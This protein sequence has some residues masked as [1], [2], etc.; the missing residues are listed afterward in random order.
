MNAKDKY[1]LARL[2]TNILQA[3][4]LFQA[5]AEGSVKPQEM[6]AYAQRGAMMLSG[7]HQTL[8]NLENRMTPSP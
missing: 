7:A 3:R 5:M 4:N 2:G 8:T 6:R 1:D